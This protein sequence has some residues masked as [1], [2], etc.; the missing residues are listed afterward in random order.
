[1]DQPPARAPAADEHAPGDGD[2]AAAARSLDACVV[3]LAPVTARAV[4]APC[5]HCCFDFACLARWLSVRPRCPVCNAP[6]RAVEHDWRSP[7]DHKTLRIAPPPPGSSD[8]PREDL[9]SRDDDDDDDDGRRRRPR[10]ARRR[11]VPRR[12][13]EEGA[14]GEL[15]EEEGHDP[16]ADPDLLRRSTVY[17][18]ARFSLHV[19]GPAAPAPRQV[20]AS[21]ALRSRVAVWVRRELR[22][23][24]PLVRARATAAAT[25]AAAGSSGVAAGGRARRDRERGS[26]RDEWLVRFAVDVLAAVPA[27]S[28]EAVE[29]LAPHLGGEALAQLFLHELASWLRSPCA[30]VE[31]WDRWVRYPPRRLFPALDKG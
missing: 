30:T 29:L 21:A 2:G 26:I 28:C 15:E 10:P 1:M 14:A 22:A 27:R 24:L 6:V 11:S 5:N 13:E 9:R 7:T 4:A 20:A 12:L 17:R 23:L 16:R 18:R 8:S 31:E 3:C 25:A 19:G